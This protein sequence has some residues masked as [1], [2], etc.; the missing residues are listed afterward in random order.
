MSVAKRWVDH[1][2]RVVVVIVMLSTA[3]LLP[4]DGLVVVLGMVMIHG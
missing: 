3:G 4:K 2:D 1:W